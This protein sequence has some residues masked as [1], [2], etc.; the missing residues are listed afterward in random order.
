M[1]KTIKQLALVLLGIIAL[2]PAIGQTVNMN[3]WVDLTVTQGELISIE[4][5]SENE[6]TFVKITSGLT[7]TTFTIGQWYSEMSK[8]F[9]QSSTMRVYGDIKTF[10]CNDNG[11]KVT[12]LNASNSIGLKNISCYNNSITNLNVSGLTT[13]ENLNCDNN[14]LASLNVSGLNALKE[15]LC[16]NNLLTNLNVDGLNALKRLYCHHNS[17]TN[18]NANGN[19]ALEYLDCYNNSITNLNISGLTALYSLNCSNNS[20]SNLN[21]SGFTTMRFLDCSNNFITSLKINGCN[22]LMSIE[23][24]TNQLSA[25][26]LDSIFHKLPTYQQS[27]LTIYIKDGSESNPGATTCRDTI[28]S[29]RNWRVADKSNFFD[30]VNSYYACPYFTLDIEEVEIIN[31]SA[32]VYPNPVSNTLSIECSEKIKSIILYDASGK[33]VF[34]TKETKDIDF[35]NLTE[36]VYILNLITDKGKGS[37]KV[38]KQ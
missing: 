22:N 8:Y 6:N 25:C 36:G 20:I 13:L 35:S 23:C 14:S 18:L 4:L 28:A 5:K 16:M 9:A 34:K 12:E 32:K 1:K 10:Y 17:I 2:T 7:D 24:F 11:S 3:R 33:E 27:N 30:I 21:V 37:Y 19:T 29:N 15:L 38:I 31:I 26:S